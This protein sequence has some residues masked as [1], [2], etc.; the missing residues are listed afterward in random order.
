MSDENDVQ[1][2]KEKFRE[3]F[4]SI[5]EDFDV[6]ETLAE[7]HAIYHVRFAKAVCEGPWKNT[8]GPHSTNF[9]QKNLRSASEMDAYCPGPED[10]ILMEEIYDFISCSDFIAAGDLYAFSI[11]FQASRVAIRHALSRL[12]R[13]NR[14]HEEVIPNDGGYINKIYRVK[15]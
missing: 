5:Y 6:S 10:N 9:I 4:R 2:L 1:L 14:V 12:I 13:D 3:V 8:P 15:K 7:V 11:S